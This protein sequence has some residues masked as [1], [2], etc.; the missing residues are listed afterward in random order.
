MVDDRMSSVEESSH[1]PESQGSFDSENAPLMR[2]VAPKHQQV[3]WGY[4][5]PLCKIGDFQWIL[6]PHWGVM[7]WTYF[8]V[9]GTCYWFFRYNHPESPTILVSSVLVMTLLSLSLIFATCSDPGIL[10]AGVNGVG[11]D[12][13][14]SC[15]QWNTD[16]S[17]A[18]TCG[19]CKVK[20]PRG[21]HHCKYCG[22]CV[23]GWDH[24]CQWMGKCIGR[25][26]VCF[27]HFFL[28]MLVLTPICFM[29]S[30]MVDASLHI[31]NEAP[32]AE[33]MAG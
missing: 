25:K 5:I 27:F 33:P 31:V 16:L 6:G 23:V 28:T 22:V 12:G 32:T 21:T 18:R 7:L 8:L 13:D 10:I 24:H 1:D 17:K 29:I 20:Q 9:F 15:D 26:N 4:M 19:I 14:A 11:L 3:R 2:T 30:A